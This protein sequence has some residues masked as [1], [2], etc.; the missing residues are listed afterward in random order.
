MCFLGALTQRELSLGG[1]G[2]LEFGGL[3]FGGHL[4]ILDS[5]EPSRQDGD[6]SVVGAGSRVRSLR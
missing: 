5:L 6:F 1:L 2:G 3:E 4:G